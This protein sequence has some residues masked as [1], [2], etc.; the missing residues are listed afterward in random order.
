MYGPRPAA[1]LCNEKMA[2]VWSRTAMV[3][4][5]RVENWPFLRLFEHGVR[6][7]CTC[8]RLRTN[9]AVFYLSFLLFSVVVVGV[10]CF[11]LWEML[12]QVKNIDFGVCKLLTQVVHLTLDTLLAKARSFADNCTFWDRIRQRECRWRIELPT[13][14]LDSV[15][16]CTANCAVATLEYNTSTAVLHYFC[17]KKLRQ[18]RASQAKGACERSGACATCARIA[19]CIAI[20]IS[21]EV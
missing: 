4:L 10:S 11:Q 19:G 18:S 16:V 17:P 1:R 6:N 21:P 13:N 7:W 8:E 12:G 20:A 3:P 2:F 15:S 5:G 9:A 14:P